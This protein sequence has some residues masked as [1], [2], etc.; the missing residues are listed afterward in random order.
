MA[1][2]TTDR[3]VH[4]Y[5][6]EQRRILCGSHSAEDHS[7]KHPR[8]VTCSDCLALLREPEAEEVRASAEVSASSGTGV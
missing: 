6:V 8:G 4:H 5:D 7:T 1:K 3:L 2:Q